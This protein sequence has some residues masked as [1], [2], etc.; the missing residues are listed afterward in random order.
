MWSVIIDTVYKTIVV[1]L[2]LRRVTKFKLI[3]EPT[4]LFQ[5]FLREYGK[6]GG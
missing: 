6:Y 1:G 5:I 2:L 4:Y 3:F